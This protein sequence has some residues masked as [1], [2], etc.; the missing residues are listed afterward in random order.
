[1]TY[2]RIHYGSYGVGFSDIIKEENISKAEEVAKESA[3][4]LFH[5]Y[6][7]D[8]GFGFGTYSWAEE[9]TKEDLTEEE[10]EIEK[11]FPVFDE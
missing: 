9:V 2:F 6:T 1:M 7:S 8:F 11:S 5:F 3:F 4:C 10:K